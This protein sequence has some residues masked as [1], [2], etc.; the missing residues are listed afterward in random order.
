[1]GFV[2]Q[3]S[4]SSQDMALLRGTEF[5]SVIL[6]LFLNI[7]ICGLGLLSGFVA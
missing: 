1:M 6:Y 5:I 4:V 3:L 7:I 2:L